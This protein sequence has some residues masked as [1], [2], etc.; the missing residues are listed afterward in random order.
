ML[1]H[2]NHTTISKPFKCSGNKIVKENTCFVQMTSLFKGHYS[3]KVSHLTAKQTPKL[4]VLITVAYK[5]ITNVKKFIVSQHICTQTKT[6]NP[7]WVNHSNGQ[8]IIY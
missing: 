1:S 8:P 2:S 7:A 3:P 4:H 6:Y 5:K